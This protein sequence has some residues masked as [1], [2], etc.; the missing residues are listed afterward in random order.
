MADVTD[1]LLRS[2]VGDK[3]ALDELLPVVYKELRQIASRQLAHENRNHT[4]QATELVHEA[5]LK[6]INQHSVDWS[7]RIQFFSIAAQTIRRI[8]TNYARDKGRQKRG[9]NPTMIEL[10]EVISFSSK[11]NIDLIDLDEALER[12][13]KVNNLKVKIIELKF[14]GGLENEEIAGVLKLSASTVK[15][16]WRVAKAWLLTELHNT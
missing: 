13:D 7:S 5:Y 3:D 10:D 12:L 16:E 6:L 15:R 9:S 14:F 8:L 4:L 2:Q 1:L 11:K